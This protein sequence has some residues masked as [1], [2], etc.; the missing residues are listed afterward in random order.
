M[1]GAATY[2][3]AGIGDMPR[4]S[5]LVS[6]QSDKA[7][8]R[9]SHTHSDAEVDIYTRMYALVADVVATYMSDACGWDE[10]AFEET[11]PFMESGLDSLDL[12]KVIQIT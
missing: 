8:M 12:L 10:G 7:A 6:T 3:Y 5:S 9:G 11:R 1:L 2:K 4:A